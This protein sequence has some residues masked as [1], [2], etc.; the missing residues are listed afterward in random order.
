ME[1]KDMQQCISNDGL[2]LI[3]SLKK[4]NNTTSTHANASLKNP[5]APLPFNQSLYKRAK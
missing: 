4:H 1:V 5:S 3:D 2:V